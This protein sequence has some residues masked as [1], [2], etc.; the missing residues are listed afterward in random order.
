MA[1]KA[2]EVYDIT[3]GREKSQGLSPETSQD[4]RGQAEEVAT[5]YVLQMYSQKETDGSRLN[6][7]HLQCQF[8]FDFWLQA[9]LEHLGIHY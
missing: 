3:W 1:F 5:L 6:I 4:L 8:S 2:V 7:S 9:F